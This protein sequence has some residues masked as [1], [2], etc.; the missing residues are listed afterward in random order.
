MNTSRLNIIKESF[1]NIPIAVCFFDSRGIVRLINRQM[2][3]LTAQLLGSHVQSL[4]ELHY[5]L[6]N[7]PPSVEQ[8]SDAPFVYRF[9]D[10]KI[11]RFSEEAV[12][13]SEGSVFIQ[14]IASEVTELID[15]QNEL[16]A[17][18]LRLSEANHR[19][20]LLYENMAEI[21]R[22]EE[23]L[24]M[25]MRIHDDIGHSILAA[26]QAL[27]KNESLEA[28]RA[29]AAVWEK[30]IELLNHANLHAE[31][32]DALA[33]ALSRAEILGLKV[34]ITGELPKESYTHYLL[35]LAIR[36]CITNCVRH[37]GSDEL[38]VNITLQNNTH[39]AV[40]T[41]NGAPPPAEICEGGG[42]S[43]LRKRLEKSGGTMTVRSFPRFSLTITLPAKEEKL[44]SM[45]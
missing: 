12:T 17:D 8:L 37:A 39:T 21:V 26:R 6:H 25:K 23:I 24:A 33:Y 28:I 22:E 43:A 32:P 15:M 27:Q 14:V 10:G 13:D 35:T 19:A 11:R 3:Q 1:D 45:S 4:S 7:P 42:L 31:E 2:L 38:Y 9:P 40:I 29:N 20:R 44:W 36:E 18:N 41:N 16:R 5:I 30:S 34:I